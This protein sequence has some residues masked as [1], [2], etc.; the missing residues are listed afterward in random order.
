M[1]KFLAITGIA[2]FLELCIWAGV[3]L[4]FNV[5]LTFDDG[6]SCTLT[7]QLVH[8]LQSKGV[9]ATFFE[10]GNMIEQCPSVTKMVHDAGNAVENHS[11]DH[12]W[13]THLSPASVAYEISRTSALIRQATGESPQYFR[14]PYGDTNSDVR[15]AAGLGQ[16][17]WTCDTDDY[18]YPTNSARIAPYIENN[19]HGGIILMHDIHPA[20]V[21]AIAEVIDRLRSEGATF[22]TIPEYFGIQ[23]TAPEPLVAQAKRPAPK[24]A[25]AAPKPAVV[26]TAK[27]APT[28]AKPG[29]PVV[30]VAK[31]TASVPT[32]VT[33][34]QR[35]YV[36]YHVYDDGD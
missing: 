9:R 3:A 30:T 32:V 26:V 16:V 13:L 22:L 24:P 31:A 25:T 23:V 2:L 12:P 8:I 29:T 36:P 19:C 15:E 4:A 11:Y 7:P 33:A 20:S 34:V 27:P 21:Y 18:K 17:M 35:E 28:P 10:V 1:R 5:M 6:P 14:P